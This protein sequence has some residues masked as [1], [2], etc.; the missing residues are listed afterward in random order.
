MVNVIG[1]GVMDSDDTFEEGYG[2]DV[3]AF[4]V[5]LKTI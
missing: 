3:C 4:L 5:E 1:V 2:F